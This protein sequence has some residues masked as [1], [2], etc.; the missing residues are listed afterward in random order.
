[1]R[2]FSTY[3]IIYSYIRQLT[4]PIV[5]LHSVGMYRSVEKNRL[6]IPCIPYGMHPVARVVAYL[7]YAVDGEGHF[8][9]L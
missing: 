4:F 5:A 2:M 7:R 9:P 8:I 1:M 6:V 3:F